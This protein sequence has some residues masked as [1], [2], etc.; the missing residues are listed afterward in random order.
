MAQLKEDEWPGDREPTTTE[1]EVANDPKHGPK[2]PDDPR[3]PEL[4]E[5]LRKGL[6]PSGKPRTQARRDTD[7]AKPRGRT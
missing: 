6:S 4:S 5:E 1:R 2:D 7:A 3:Q